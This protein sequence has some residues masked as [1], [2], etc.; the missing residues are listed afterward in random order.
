MA[1]GFDMTS[2]AGALKARFAKD[3]VESMAYKDSPLMAMLTK[4][5]DF[6]GE[7]WVQPVMYEDVHARSA[8]F[9]QAQT[10]STSEESKIARFEVTRVKDYGVITVD[11]EL[12]EA[13]KKDQDAFWKGTTTKI[14]SIMRA[15]AQSAKISL[16]RKGWGSI[17]T[18]S[19]PTAST[20]LT[21]TNKQDI[22]NFGKGMVVVY[23]ASE[24]GHVLLDSGES[25]TVVSVDR[26][27]GTLVMSA[28]VT[29]IAAIADGAH[30]FVKGDREDSATPTR[31][32]IAG[33]ED[34]IP[35]TAPAST[36]FFGVDRT[37]DTRLG[38]CRLD[39]TSPL[40]NLEEALIEGAT[41]CNREGGSP[42]YAF[43]NPQKVGDLIKLLG[44]K[45]SYVDVAV[46]KMGF[47]GLEVH[48]PTGTVKVIGDRFCPVDRAFLLQ[49]DTWALGSL[50]GIPRILNHDSLES[51]RQASDD[52]IEIRV[53]YYGNLY[54]KAP[55]WNCNI[56]V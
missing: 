4:N 23:S 42:D 34:W 8:T 31:K 33:L 19:T 11:G 46:G 30:I 6:G 1:S 25:Q 56:K 20:T 2:F 15:T 55:G 32:K 28:N 26:N 12:I 16:Y 7:K 40:L 10:L 41:L 45:V 22:V 49:M 39:S 27:A 24:A 17:G 18:V 36:S 5:E 53:G 13:S 14:E 50:G 52:G 43:M 48:L 21:L 37:L 47:R 3:F 38:G 9:S 51:L 44:S 35:Q 29:G 54:C